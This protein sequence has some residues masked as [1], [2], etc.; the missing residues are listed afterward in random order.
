MKCTSNTFHWEPY[1]SSRLSPLIPHP[2]PHHQ[3]LRLVLDFS[4]GACAIK[5]KTE[6]GS[7]CGI[8]ELNERELDVTLPVRAQLSSH[9]GKRPSV[10]LRYKAKDPD[11][12]YIR[13]Y[14]GNLRYAWSIC[15][16]VKL[17]IPGYIGL[18]IH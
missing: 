16:S 8:A 12:E 15:M 11:R 3:G 5:S 17:F 18:N 4:E 10:F 9:D 6:N 13:V 1:S 7:C 2:T 14:P